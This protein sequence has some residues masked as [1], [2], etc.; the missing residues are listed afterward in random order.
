LE[1][2]PKAE[3]GAESRRA[4]HTTT[5]RAAGRGKN[6]GKAA[7]WGPVDEKS[8]LG[9]GAEGRLMSCS[10]PVTSDSAMTK[11]RPSQAAKASPTPG[12]G[13][14]PA[15]RGDVASRREE[16]TFE[17]ARSLY[18]AFEPIPLE[19]HQT[20]LYVDLDSVRGDTNVARNLHKEIQFSNKPKT[21]LVA[22][23]KGCG[24]STELRRLYQQLNSGPRPYFTVLCTER[25]IDTVNVEFTDVLIVVLQRVA[26]EL[27]KF[28]ISLTSGYLEDLRARIS[29]SLFT[30]V[31]VEKVD[32]S[33]GLAKISAAMKSS[34]DVRQ[35]VRKLLQSETSSLQREINNSLELATS[36]LANR[37]YAGLVV[38]LD[39]LDRIFD[40]EQAET[41]FVQRATEMTSFACQLVVTMPI[42]L[43]YSESVQQLGTT[44]ANR[45]TIVPMTKLRTRPVAR[46][47]HEPG[48]EKFRQIVDKR[49]RQIGVDRQTVFAGDEVLTALIEVTGGQPTELMSYLQELIVQGQLP[50]TLADVER[51][52]RVR[53]RD[54]R[55]FVAEDWEV[56]ESFERNGHYEPT[57]KTRGVLKRLLDGRAILQYLNDDEWY[58]LN[59]VVRQLK[60]PLSSE[61]SAS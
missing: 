18:Q 35:Q 49:L 37:H 47:R 59:P 15:P 57:E 34:P 27:R 29:K 43:A 31:E 36:E 5:L 1:G 61:T 41:L 45:P 60:R 30:E 9:Q 19:A 4:V 10:N 46:E 20:D 33:M 24:K 51:L 26:Q 56:V 14:T 6:R 42:S 50:V 44:Y 25:D 54:Y 13:V 21:W 55:W 48:F 16:E 38:I 3:E 22:G 11:R 39:S 17:V 53:S 40:R 2:L 58:D 32:L 12:P 8:W 28:S 7:K 23:H 52:T